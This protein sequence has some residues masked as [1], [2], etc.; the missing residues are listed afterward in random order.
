MSQ[1]THPAA[2][3]HSPFG[4]RRT[5]ILL[6]LLGLVAA[7][8]VVMA[9]TLG[10]SDATPAGSIVSDQPAAGTARSAE[11]GT[12]FDGGPEEGTRGAVAAP[13]SPST[14]FDG[15]PE[16]GTRGA[17]AAPGTASTRSDGDPR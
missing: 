5:A 10:G 3:A 14:R 11:P 1:T 2:P 8:L 12:R 7:I 16:E 6:G 17:V 9:L 4:V 15:G 13:S